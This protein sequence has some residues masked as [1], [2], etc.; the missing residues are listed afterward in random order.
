VKT[1]VACIMSGPGRPSMGPPPITVPPGIASRDSILKRAHEAAQAHLHGDEDHKKVSSDWRDFF[2]DQKDVHVPERQCTFHV[3]TAGPKSPPEDGHTVPVVF[4]VHGGGYTG[5]SFALLA[6][7]LRDECA[8]H[9]AAATCIVLMQPPCHVATAACAPACPAC[10]HPQ[11]QLICS[12]TRDAADAC[13]YRVVAFDMRHH[14]K[15]MMD[16]ADAEH[17]FSRQTLV[18]DIYAVWRALFA[19][20]APPTVLVGHS[21]GGALATWAAAAEV[22]EG[23]GITSLEGLIVIDVVEGT[24][25]GTLQ[26]CS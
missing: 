17:D 26:R 4:C 3:Y 23:E 13:R 22:G 20:E 15:T 14:G 1:T 5:L 11:L 8:H 6:E 18:D 24:A 10:H 16:D 25:M 2:H 21:V 12:Q 19:E 7:G 9:A